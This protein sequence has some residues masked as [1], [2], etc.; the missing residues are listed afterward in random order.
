MF[1]GAKSTVFIFIFV[2]WMEGGMHLHRDRTSGRKNFANYRELILSNSFFMESYY[3]FFIEGPIFLASFPSM[4]L[5]IFVTAVFPIPDSF[6]MDFIQ[7]CFCP[8]TVAS[9][10]WQWIQNGILIPPLATSPQPHQLLLLIHW[11][12]CLHPRCGGSCSKPFTPTSN[13][14]PL[15]A[16]SWS[17]WIVIRH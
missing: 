8:T 15:E 3:Y 14:L 16:D 13:W 2:Y 10:R 6:I 4:S 12:N 11:G 5:S 17:N 7:T 1:S 9:P